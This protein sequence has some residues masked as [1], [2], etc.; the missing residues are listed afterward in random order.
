L[1]HIEVW[2]QT[3]ARGAAGQPAVR[4]AQSDT[5]R[6]GWTLAQLVAQHTLGGCSLRTRRAVASAT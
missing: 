1:V 6:L 2:L 4:V 5:A 3:A